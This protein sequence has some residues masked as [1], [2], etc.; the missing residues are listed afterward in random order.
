MNLRK[1]IIAAAFGILA[2]AA[3]AA[4]NQ[5]SFTGIVSVKPQ[6]SS[7]DQSRH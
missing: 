3:F 7:G 2:A 6:E 4:D 5:Q 1:I